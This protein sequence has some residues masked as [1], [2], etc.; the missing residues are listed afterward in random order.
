MNRRPKELLSERLE[1][2]IKELDSQY[3]CSMATGSFALRS[4]TDVRE[5]AHA[6]V[7]Y[8]Y[9]CS[10]Y[11]L[12]RCMRWALSP[13]VSLAEGT[14]RTDLDVLL[15]LLAAV[16]DVHG[17]VEAAALQE[18]FMKWDSND[19]DLVCAWLDIVGQCSFVR[20]CYR[21]EWEYACCFWK[22]LKGQRDGGAA[23]DN[24]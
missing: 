7:M 16:P 6:H 14:W 24:F 22:T 18:K 17:P 4:M 9:P 21:E 8:E 20:E 1:D 23:S 19:V 11:L 2:R 5:A 10:A 3:N 12:F 15:F 13:S